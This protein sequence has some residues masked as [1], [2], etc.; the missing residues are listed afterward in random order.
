[1]AFRMAGLTRTKSGAWF[2]RKAVPE[3]L[4]D[5]HKALYGQR[6]EV[7]FHAAADIPLSK[8]KVLHSE[9]EAEVDNRFAIL[10]AKQRG[11]GHDLTRQEARA[12]A[13]EWYRWFIGQHEEDSEEDSRRRDL[14]AALWHLLE[15]SGCRL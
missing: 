4:R 1:M 13:G 6:H 10:S 7:L 14:S 2:S 9:W 3:G 8:A 15:I 11:E 12:L 5:T